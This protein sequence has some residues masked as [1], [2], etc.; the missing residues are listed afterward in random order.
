[1]LSD[2][3]NPAVSSLFQPDMCGLLRLRCEFLGCEVENLYAKSVAGKAGEQAG[4]GGRNG[5]EKVR[6]EWVPSGLQAE[7]L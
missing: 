6:M 7:R 4:P 3:E 5:R 2:A 1:M